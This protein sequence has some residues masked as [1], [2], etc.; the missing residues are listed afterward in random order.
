MHPKRRVSA[1]V[2]VMNKVISEILQ[3]KEQQEEDDYFETLNRG[4]IAKMR[5]Q[6]VAGDSS[7]AGPP[8]QTVPR[9]LHQPDQGIRSG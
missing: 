2:S 9:R 4:V 1:E 3:R 5:R 8:A 7:G 6:G